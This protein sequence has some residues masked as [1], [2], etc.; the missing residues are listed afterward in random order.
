MDKVKGRETFEDGM[1]RAIKICKLVEEEMKD[2]DFYVTPKMIAGAI[3]KELDA[4]PTE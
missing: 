2:C 1:R 4:G 3:Q